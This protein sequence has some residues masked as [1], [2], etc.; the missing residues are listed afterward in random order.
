MNNRPLLHQQFS[1]AQT[2][3]VMSAPST[4]DEA[5]AGR[6]RL[7]MEQH[8]VTGE[9]LAECLGVSPAA[10]ARWRRKGTITRDH[11]VALARRFE[12]SI[13]WL[14]TGELQWGETPQ[15]RAWIEQIEALSP[16]QLRRLQ[17]IS[18]ALVVADNDGEYSTN[19]GTS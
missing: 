10:V 17:A 12:V 1:S 19:N 2:M 13:D 8:D 16:Q 6:I 15:R 18:D 5:L 14:L 7:L 11:L 4:S 9:Q 3:A